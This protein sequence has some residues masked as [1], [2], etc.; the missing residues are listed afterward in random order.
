MSTHE[1]WFDPSTPVQQPRKRPY[2]IVVEQ[3]LCKC[4]QRTS[5]NQQTRAQDEHALRLAEGPSS[6][7][8]LLSYVSSSRSA[9]Y[10]DIA[11][12]IDGVVRTD[13]DDHTQ[14]LRR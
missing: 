11:L 7:V 10:N 8:D 3:P 4:P 6:L 14:A 2:Y 1:C 5:F 12:D 9:Y 13:H